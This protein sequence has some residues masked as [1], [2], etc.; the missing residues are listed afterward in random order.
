MLFDAI[1]SLLSPRLGSSSS[2]TPRRHGQYFV[3]AA[4]TENRVAADFPRKILDDP[5]EI[6]VLK[7]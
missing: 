2:P 7:K 1:L 4:V 6:R 5:F 3:N